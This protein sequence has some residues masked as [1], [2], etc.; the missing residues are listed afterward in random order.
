MAPWGVSRREAEREREKQI[1]EERQ[2]I[3]ENLKWC[4]FRN[5]R[6]TRHLRISD[7]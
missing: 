6:W 7:I 2:S 4:I 1:K 3:R 5:D